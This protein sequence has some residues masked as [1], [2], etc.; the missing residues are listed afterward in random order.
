MEAFGAVMI[1]THEGLEDKL[2]RLIPDEVARERVLRFMH[3]HSHG[4]GVMR[5]VAIPDLSE[6][7]DVTKICLNAVKAWDEQYFDQLCANT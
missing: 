4:T 2:D 5:A 1:P 3:H 7:V 6:C